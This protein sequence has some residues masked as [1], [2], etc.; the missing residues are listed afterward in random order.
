MQYSTSTTPINSPPQP[1]SH[2]NGSINS[3]LE[4]RV[5]S[6]DPFSEVLHL[7]SS[8]PSSPRRTIRQVDYDI[9][10]LM[11][12]ESEL[13]CSVCKNF[14]DLPMTSKCQHTFC[15]GCA[16]FEYNN[17]LTGLC[18]PICG[19]SFTSFTQFYKN[20]M[21]EDLIKEYKDNR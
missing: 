16:K 3:T 5:E 21:I 7:S 20:I 13:K 11:K 6:I 14:Y 4:S 12:L 19:V 10:E 18:C 15:A 2:T 9:K 17:N 8:R 1:S